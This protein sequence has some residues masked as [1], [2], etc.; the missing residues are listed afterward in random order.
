LDRSRFPK[1][2][3]SWWATIA[4]K[5]STADSGGMCGKK[6]SE[7]KRFASI[8]RG[9]DRAIGRSGSDGNDSEKEFN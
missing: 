4:I 9:A 5:V 6:K 7:G 3:I 8:G 2:R 1:G